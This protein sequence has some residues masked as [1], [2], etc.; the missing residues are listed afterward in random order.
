MKLVPV[1]DTRIVAPKSAT[2]KKLT[3][4]PGK[5]V[6]ESTYEWKPKT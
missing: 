4:I 6:A 5:T 3:P 1:D 2:S